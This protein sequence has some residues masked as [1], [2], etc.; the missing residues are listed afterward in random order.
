MV[1][2][3]QTKY[4]PG[5]V[6]IPLRLAIYGPRFFK[7]KNKRTRALSY[8]ESIVKTIEN[9]NDPKCSSLISIKNKMKSELNANS[10]WKN[11]IFLSSLKSL[12]ESGAF[13][14]IKRSYKLSPNFKK[15]K[16]RDLQAKKTSRS[17]R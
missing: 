17:K 11:T 15:E 12:V 16:V 5:L 9:L 1:R 3:K 14:Q 10:K 8:K 6:P 4:K 7:K 13:I 2:T